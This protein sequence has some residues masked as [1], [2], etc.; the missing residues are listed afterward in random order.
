MP[1]WGGGRDG[2]W[3]GRGWWGRWGGWGASGR[4]GHGRWVTAGPG[5]GAGPG[6]GCGP[7]GVRSARPRVGA[8]GAARAGAL[9][10]SPAPGARW[11]QLDSQSEHARQTAPRRG[12]G[13]RSWTAKASTHGKQPRAGGPVG[14]VGQPKRART[15]NSPAPGARWARLGSQSE[16]ARQTA[17]RAGVG[18]AGAGR[19]DRTR[20]AAGAPRQVAPP[21]RSPGQRAVAPASVHARPCNKAAHPPWAP[22]VEG[23][24]RVRP[25]P[26]RSRTPCRHDSG[27]A[28]CG[29]FVR[30]RRP[31]LRPT[32]SCQDATK[33]PS[34]PPPARPST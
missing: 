30:S 1:G 34:R 32:S 31:P 27:A 4:G 7:R 25:P 9:G 28:G 22:P 24:S 29:G 2:W 18:A 8:A 20:G 14:A 19:H 16:H 26:R 10:N 11:A 6:G 3:R 33:T 23:G 15:A 13:G 17:P 21:R 5:V 12:P